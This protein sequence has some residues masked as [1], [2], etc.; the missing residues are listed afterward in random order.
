MGEVIINHLTHSRMMI[1][2]EL[3]TPEKAKTLKKNDQIM[4]INTGQVWFVDHVEM[5]GVLPF[6]H[7]W[8]GT[9]PEKL[10]RSTITPERLHLFRLIDNQ[11]PVTADEPIV[12]S[13]IAFEALR[14]NLTEALI[15]TKEAATVDL[16]V[17]DAKHIA[18]R[19]ED[20]VTGEPELTKPAR[21]P[22]K[23]KE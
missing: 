17:E 9:D 5:R 23:K 1:M 6:V 8:R 21:K 19:I 22:R 12:P 11:K 3:F 20:Y 10:S 14:E 13:E 18:E 16:T 15:E 7:V 4:V 2:F